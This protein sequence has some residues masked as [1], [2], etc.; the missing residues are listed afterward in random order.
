MG[1]GYLYGLDLYRQLLFDLKLDFMFFF[2]GGGGIK[3]LTTLAALFIFKQTN[4]N[5][6]L[7]VK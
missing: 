1:G 4:Y 3:I 7:E 5:Y 2:F 6:N